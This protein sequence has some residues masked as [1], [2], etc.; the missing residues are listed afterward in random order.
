VLGPIHREAPRAARRAPAPARI[1]PIGG[2]E[3]EGQRSRAP[4]LARLPRTRRTR[5]IGRS[6][7]R[8]LP[9]RPVFVADL[10]LAASLQACLPHEISGEPCDVSTAIDIAIDRVAHLPGPI[11]IVSDEHDAGVA[12]ENLGGEMQ[13]VLTG[14]IDDKARALRPL[15]E[16]PVVACPAGGGVLV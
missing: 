14:E 16:M 6:V 3:A 13:L 10:S 5:G 11:L 8:I 12:L 1:E 7:H 15:K 9:A 2:I 4:R